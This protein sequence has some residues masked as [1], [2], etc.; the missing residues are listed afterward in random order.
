[1]TTPKTERGRATRER[2][3]AHADELIGARGVAATSIDEIL[4]AAGASK[5]QMYH[6]FA[7]R[8]DLVR[9]VVAHRCEHFLAQFAPSLEQ[10]DSLRS[11]E[12]WFDGQVAAQSQCGFVGGCPLGSLANELADRD[13]DSRSQLAAAFASLERYLTEALERIRE[14][15]ELRADASSATLATALL[16]GIEGGLLLSQI[17]KDGEP[18]RTALEASLAH[19]RSFAA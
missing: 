6:Y 5:S 9:A 2:I 15:G 10:V 1:M 4:A 11:L 7:D 17:H 16:A 3:V 19:V 13:E 14:R 12:R 8:E 18:L